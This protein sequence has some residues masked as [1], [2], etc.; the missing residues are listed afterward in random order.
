MTIPFSFDALLVFGALSIMLLV[1]VVL[2][3][4]VALLQRF[5]FP[6]CLIGGLIGLVGMSIGL[7][8]I[9]PGD[10][11]HFGFHFF[12]ISFIS[13]GLTSAAGSRHLPGERHVLR[14]PLWMAL[15]EGVTLPL[16]ALIGG[17]VVTAFGLAGRPLFPTFGFL[18]PLGF[19]EGPGQALSVGKVWEGFGFAHAATLGLTFAALGFFFAFFVGVPLVN[20]GIRRGFATFSDTQPSADV[21]QGFLPL[22]SGKPPAGRLPMHS[23]NIDTLAFQSALVGLVYVLTYGFIWL[24]ARFLPPDAAKII[25]GFFFFI[26]MAVALVVK[27]LMI[28]LGVDYLVDPGVQRRI[29]GWAVDYLIVATVMGIQVVVVWQYI[30]PIALAAVLSGLATT[31]VVIYL[32]SRMESLH[33]ERT[34]AIYGTCTGTISSGL[35]LLRVVDPEFKTPVAMEIGLMNVIVVPIILGSM[36]LVNAPVWWDWGMGLTL[37]VFTLI[38]LSCLAAIR[39]LKFWGPPRFKQ[40]TDDRGTRE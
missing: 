2:R 30:L 27:Q 24:V 12:N 17:L 35:L 20:W 1:G 22:K 7:I 3:A 8:R 21:L 39:L 23:G 11:E 4:R 5:L 31:A 16:Q 6:A 32:G 10:I 29:T 33:L 38:G 25:W 9:P 15:V 19:T 13:V 40:K 18:V 26:G 37:L 34:V 28:R 14:G 36:I